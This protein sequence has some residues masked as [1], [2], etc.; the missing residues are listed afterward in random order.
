LKLLLD[1]MYS[2][3]VA[4]ILREAGHDVVAVQE[5]PGL[6]GSSDADLLSLA[7]AEG[8]TLVTENIDDFAVLHRNLLASGGSHAGLVFIHPRRFPR[9]RRDHRR[10]L[11]RALTRLLDDRPAGLV[12]SFVWF[13]ESS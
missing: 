8:R 9:E 6:S 3:A 7:A 2:A 11:T 12:E 13:L 10:R 5:V 1:E 4:G